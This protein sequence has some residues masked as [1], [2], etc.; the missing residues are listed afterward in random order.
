[1]TVFTVKAVTILCRMNLVIKQD[2][3]GTCGEYD[4]HRFFRDFL[5]ERGI[6]HNA[7]D[8]QDGSQ[9][10]DKHEFHL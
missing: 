6:T 1:M 10:V 9:A 3:S 4:S 5:R 8:K 7:D 2:I